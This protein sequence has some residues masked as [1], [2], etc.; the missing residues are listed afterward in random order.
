MQ[1]VGSQPV[2]SV[3]FHGVRGSTPCHGDEVARYGGNTS[4]VSVHVPGH[5]PVLFDMGTGMR[6]FG[7]RQPVD[8]PFDEADFITRCLALGKQYQLQR[9]IRSAESV[10]RVLF[11]TALSLARN[12]GLID[13]AQK[14]LAARRAVFAEEIRGAIR[15]VDAIDALDAGRRAGLLL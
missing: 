12:R 1:A 11:Q 5:D 3:T 7:M 2:M 6:Y 14:D 10:S 8:A 4:C 13:P 15:R 9:Q